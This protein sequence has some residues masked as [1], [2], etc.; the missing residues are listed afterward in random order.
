MKLA[1]RMKDKLKADQEMKKAQNIEGA[2]VS[3]D[4]VTGEML[5]Y[6]GG[7]EF[8]AKNQNDH[9]AQIRRQP[10][11][12]FKPMV[13]AAAMESKDINPSTVFV[14]EKT[15]FRGRIHAAQL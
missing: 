15:D 8:S 1:G 5:A 3:I 6:V 4:P 12:S 14:D 9:V 13:Y 2:L 10:G 7:Y 11:S